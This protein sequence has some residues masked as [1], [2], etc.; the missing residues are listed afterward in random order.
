MGRPPPPLCGTGPECQQNEI[1]C[2]KQHIFSCSFEAKGICQH[3]NTLNRTSGHVAESRWTLRGGK[4]VF[5]A[6]VFQE[7]HRTWHHPSSLHFC[8]PGV[9]N[10]NT[11]LFGVTRLMSESRGSLCGVFPGTTT[12]LLKVGVSV[13]VV[14]GTNTR[15]TSFFQH[16]QHFQNTVFFTY[17]LYLSASLLLLLTVHNVYWCFDVAGLSGEKGIQG[18]RGIKGPV[19]TDG[20]KGEKGDVGPKGA[21]GAF[22]SFLLVFYSDPP[23]QRKTGGLM[24]WTL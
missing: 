24:W 5:P 12:G 23:V 17:Q 15:T 21:R 1:I 7:G 16:Q 6:Y 2:V 13:E 8:V 19:G 18:P 22:S 9:L 20:S 14:F 10:V 11:L 3:F 4:H